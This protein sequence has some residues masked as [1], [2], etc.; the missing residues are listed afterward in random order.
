MASKKLK[1]KKQIVFK[2]ANTLVKI[3]IT[4]VNMKL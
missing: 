4:G 3:S 1:K 2:Q